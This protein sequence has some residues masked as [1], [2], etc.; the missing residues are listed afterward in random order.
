MP[1][2]VKRRWEAFAQLIASGSNLIDAYVIVGYAEKGAYAGASRLKSRPEVRDRIIELQTAS[3]DQAIEKAA[4]SQKYVLDR[5][6]AIVERCMQRQEITDSK[7]KST[8]VWRFDAA[9]ATR[10][11]ELLG[12]QLGMFKDQRLIGVKRIDD[13]TEEEIV[14][15]LGEGAEG[16]DTGRPHQN[17]SGE[18]PPTTH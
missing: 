1:V 15:F 18:G 4:L 6:M 9:A 11:L 7:G 8:G 2:L 17:G 12:K 14:A 16:G 3:I 10:A 5:L 13:M